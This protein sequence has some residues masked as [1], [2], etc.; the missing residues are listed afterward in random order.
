MIGGTRLSTRQQWP[1]WFLELQRQCLIRHIWH[2][3]NPDI[4]KGLTG[5][6]AEMEV[7]TTIGTD[8]LAASPPV[9]TTLDSLRAELH[10]RNLANHALLLEA[11]KPS[12]KSS[13]TPTTS[14][15]TTMSGTDE[16]GKE[17]AKETIPLPPYPTIKDVSEDF[18]IL[19]RDYKV[20][21]GSY[22]LYHKSFDEIYS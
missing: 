10:Q 11:S 1:M 5:P 15:D 18:S 2:L 20:R 8:W 21:K 14:G 6:L 22:D 3:V 17:T 4:Y 7:E 16:N 19:E 9:P 12:S 13:D